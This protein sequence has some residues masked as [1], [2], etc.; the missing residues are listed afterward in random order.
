MY[1]VY[2]LRSSRIEKLYTGFTSDLKKRLSEH[3]NGESAF[4]K[5]GRSWELVYYEAY[6]NKKDAMVR[7]KYLKTGWG[8][9]YIRKI[10][11]N[12]LSGKK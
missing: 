1:Y 11:N 12:Y 3:N 5:F 6:K 9:N 2:V 7:E 4:T 8:R 10:L